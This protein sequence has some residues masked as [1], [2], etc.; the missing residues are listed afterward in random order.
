MCK[1]CREKKKQEDNKR[2]M[3][4]MIQAKPSDAQGINGSLDVSLT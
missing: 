3:S 4:D 2:H 1:N